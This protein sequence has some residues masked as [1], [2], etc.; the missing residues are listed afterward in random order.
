MKD[1]ISGQNSDGLGESYENR[2]IE[3]EDGD[4]HVHFWHSGNDY[5]IVTDSE[6]DQELHA[7]AYGIDG[8]MTGMSM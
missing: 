7:T 2:P 6:V 3:T 4:L 5:F 1:W 8:G